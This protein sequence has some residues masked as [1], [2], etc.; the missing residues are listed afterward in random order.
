MPTSGAAPA[1]A[2]PAS[3]SPER[4]FLALAAP[5]GLAFLLAIGPFEG[6]DE[7]AHFL[8]AFQVSE[9]GL[10]ARRVDRRVGGWMPRSIGVTRLETLEDIP[11][12]R[13]R[14][15]DPARI[16]RMLALPL[17]PADRLFLDF[18]NSA[19]ASPVSYLP[20]AAAMGL[21]R[22]LGLSPLLLLYLG[23]GLNLAAWTLL[24]HAAI[25]AAPLRKWLLVALALSP[26]SLFQA[27]TLSADAATNA[28]AALWLACCLRER[29]ETAPLAAGR[30]ALLAALAAALALSKAPYGVLVLLW[31]LLPWRRFGSRARF[32]AAS[33]A[34]VGVSAALAVS[35]AVA[36]HAINLPHARYNP[37]YR[38]G[39][40]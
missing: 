34:L 6:A 24:T 11:L 21:G 2:I 17:D 29:R 4:A 7:F 23:R 36:V 19:L 12:H 28:L 26:V 13:D 9:G 39:Q 1:A 25:R 37:G 33:A 27:S 22:L 31:F 15:H 5:F 32:A 35:W 14:T 8:R 16:R 10:L 30:L 18:P 40:A 3:V 38:S 20:Q